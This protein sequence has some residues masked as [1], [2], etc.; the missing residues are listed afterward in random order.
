M[1]E[2]VFTNGMMLWIDTFFQMTDAVIA[3]YNNATDL[4]ENWGELTYAQSDLIDTNETQGYQGLR[5]TAIEW[6]NEFELQDTPFKDNDDYLDRIE[7]F[8]QSKLIDKDT[9]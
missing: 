4:A 9:L 3:A 7:A 6:A 5:D 1:T 8:V 2:P